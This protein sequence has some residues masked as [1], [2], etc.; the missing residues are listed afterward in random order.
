MCAWGN[1]IRVG[2]LALVQRSELKR[3]TPMRPSQTRPKSPSR[4]RQPR[5]DWTEARAKVE[6]EG[7]CRLAGVGCPTMTG[8]DCKETH[9]ECVYECFGR[10]EAAHII[11]RACDLRESPYHDHLSVITG[12]TW[13]YR[14]RV[15]P[16]C[17]RHHRQYDRHEIDVLGR[18]TPEEEAQA[19]IDADGLEN[20]RVR[21]CPSAYK[22]TEAA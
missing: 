13:V 1:A 4:P 17:S 18:L 2:E 10:L 19:V 11:G 9:G 22:R 3:K 8:C 16:L 5:R 20:A 21:I 14:V 15:V 7:V 6:A 12:R